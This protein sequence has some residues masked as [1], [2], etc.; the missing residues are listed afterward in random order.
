MFG[1][2]RLALN[3]VQHKSFITP[4]TADIPLYIYEILSAFVWWYRM[5]SGLISLIRIRHCDQRIYITTTDRQ[6]A[7]GCGIQDSHPGSHAEATIARSWLPMRQCYKIAHTMAG[8]YIQTFLNLFARAKTGVGWNVL[9]RQLF[10]YI[11]YLWLSNR[12]F[13]VWPMFCIPR[14][15][16]LILA[17]HFPLNPKWLLCCITDDFKMGLYRSAS[18]TMRRIPRSECWYS[19]RILGCIQKGD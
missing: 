9:L 19:I 15:A 13:F 7:W 4:Y 8:V 2:D 6:L 1:E 16:H 14:E 17:V 10:S 5:I 3:L 18:K 12:W 11:S